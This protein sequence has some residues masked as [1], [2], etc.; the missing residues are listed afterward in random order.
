MAAA[1]QPVDVGR[2]QM[3]RGIRVVLACDDLLKHS[4]LRRELRLY[5]EMCVVGEATDWKSLE[6]ILEEYAPEL[7]VA[8]AALVRQG[9]QYSTTMFPLF[10][11]V[12]HA[13]FPLLSSR[14]M[15]TLAPYSG[16]AQIA[17]TVQAMKVAVLET[18]WQEVLQMLRASRAAQELPSFFTEIEVTGDEGPTTIAVE[19]VICVLAAKNYVHLETTSGVFRTRAAMSEIAT[20]MDP[21]RYVRIHRSAI[22]HKAFVASVEQHDGDVIAVTLCNGSRVPVG[23]TYRQAALA[24]IDDVEF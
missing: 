9:L 6:A 5:P 23:G 21:S 1:I 3:L 8:T 19:Q 12:A 4:E 11:P 17:V 2:A 22:V 16:V 20:R 7:V 24:L 14:V 13:H 18:K 15:A 10:V